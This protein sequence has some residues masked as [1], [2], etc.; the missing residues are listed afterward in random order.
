[1]FFVPYLM[2]TLVITCSSRA[3]FHI[4]SGDKSWCGLVSLLE[5]GPWLGT[6]DGMHQSSLDLLVLVN[7]GD[8]FLSALFMKYGGSAIVDDLPHNIGSR[9]D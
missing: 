6:F 9:D 4:V 8:H 3:L 1:M 7:L 2:L 5:D